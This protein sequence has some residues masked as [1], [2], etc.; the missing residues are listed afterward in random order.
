MID[1]ELAKKKQFL[2]TAYPGKEWARKV[3]RMPK[4]QVTAIYFSIH[5]R[6]NKMPKKAKRKEKGGQIS[7]FDYTGTIGN[8]KK[9]FNKLV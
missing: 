1:R 9:M 8:E 2:K 6:M 3:D 7:I 4:D 5:D